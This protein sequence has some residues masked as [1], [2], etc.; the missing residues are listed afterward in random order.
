MTKQV[1][2][3]VI[4]MNKRTLLRRV[5]ITGF[6]SAML[7][8]TMFVVFTNVMS[9]TAGS[10]PVIN[11]VS[12][13]SATLLQTTTIRGSGFGD[14]QPVI[15]PLWDGSVN[16]VGGGKNMPGEGGTPV[17]QVNNYARNTW[18]SGVQDAP[19]KMPAWPGRKDPPPIPGNSRHPT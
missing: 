3:S 16:T 8:F 13:I 4:T 17:M 9:V 18:G 7:C 10:S 15:S 11:S 19:W 12:P 6:I 1:V 14:T 2:I 5:F